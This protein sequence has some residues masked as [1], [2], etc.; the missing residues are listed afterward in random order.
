MWQKATPDF[1]ISDIAIKLVLD[2]VK[3]IRTLDWGFLCYT[4]KECEFRFDLPYLQI[5]SFL[6]SIPMSKM[7]IAMETDRRNP[8]LECLF[9]I[10]DYV[11]A[12]QYAK[13]EAARGLRILIASVRRRVIGQ[14]YQSHRQQEGLEEDWYLP[15]MLMRN[16][17][18]KGHFGE[19][20]AGRPWE[21]STREF[22]YPFDKE[23]WIRKHGGEEVLRKM[24][25]ILTLQRKRRMGGGLWGR[26]QKI[27]LWDL[28]CAIAA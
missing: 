26:C 17:H 6:E 1:D 28:I 13:N 2:L 23:V 12:S 24:Q 21:K 5:Q 10:G 7:R 16:S 25:G 14:E 19:G 18:I 11:S 9:P 22:Q 8:H 4:Q 20:E 27:G 3:F 15:E